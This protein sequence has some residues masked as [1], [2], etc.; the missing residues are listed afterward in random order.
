MQSEPPLE[1]LKSVSC[2]C[3]RGQHI[4]HER[5]II[6][7]SGLEWSNV[8]RRQLLQNERGESGIYIDCPRFDL[9]LGRL[10]GCHVYPISSEFLIVDGPRLGLSAIPVD[11]LSTLL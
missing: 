6:N 2:V 4:H 9:V 1:T 5:L 7:P 10:G 11:F 3:L 8:W